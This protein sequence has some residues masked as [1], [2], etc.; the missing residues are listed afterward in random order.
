[1]QLDLLVFVLSLFSSFQSFSCVRLFAT[2]QTAACQA[3]LSITNSWSLLKIMSIDL[4]MPSNYLIL[5]LPLLLLPS[6]FP[7]IRVF[8]NVSACL[9]CIESLLKSTNMYSTPLCPHCTPKSRPD[10]K[11]CRLKADS[12]TLLWRFHLKSFFL[13][14][15][16]KL[17]ASIKVNRL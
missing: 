15:E 9:V 5:C 6:I 7:N 12:S 1:M 16:E 4:V 3:S 2:P 8:S 17:V 11:T 10:T 14:G 13:E